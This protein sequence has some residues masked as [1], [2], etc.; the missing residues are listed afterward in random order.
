MSVDFM[1]C[2]DVSETLK[3]AYCPRQYFYMTQKFKES[4]FYKRYCAC[5]P[6]RGDIECNRAAC[7]NILESR[8]PYTQ[9]DYIRISQKPTCPSDFFG[10]LAEYANTCGVVPATAF[11]KFMADFGNTEFCAHTCPIGSVHCFGK[12]LKGDEFIKNTCW[13]PLLAELKDRQK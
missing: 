12:E 9:D 2:A 4:D 5:V 7:W 3:G 13:S 8:G 10:R 11:S 1:A 6:C